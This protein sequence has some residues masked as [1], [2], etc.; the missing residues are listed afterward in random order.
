MDPDVIADVL[1]LN[2]AD[3]GSEPFVALVGAPST[4]TVTASLNVNPPEKVGF[5][6]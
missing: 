5:P 2:A 1:I 3:R 4:S 6:I